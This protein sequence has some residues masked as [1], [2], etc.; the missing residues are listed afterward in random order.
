MANAGTLLTGIPAC[1]NDPYNALRV[2]YKLE[3]RAGVI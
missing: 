3:D 1:V 2:K